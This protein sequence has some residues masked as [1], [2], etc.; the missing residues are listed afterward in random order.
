MRNLNGAIILLIT[1]LICSLLFNIYLLCLEN[2]IVTLDSNMRNGLISITLLRNISKILGFGLGAL[3]QYISVWHYTFILFFT[4]IILR[5]VHMK[6]ADTPLA[7][8]LSLKQ[9]NYR[10][11]IVFL[12]CL[13][14]VAVFSIPQLIQ[15]LHAHGMTTYSSLA[16]MLPG[17][18]SILYLKYLKDT[19]F[20]HHLKLKS[21]TY[22]SFI[23]FY[24]IL[25]YW[26]TFLFIRMIII[27][28]I[29]TISISI[30][31]DIRAQFIQQNSQVALRNL[32][33]FMSLISAL[34]L[35]V[36]SVIALFLPDI[37]TIILIINIVA[38]SILM[39][40]KHKSSEDG[41]ST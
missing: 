4:F 20:N 23:S 14:S 5:T 34:S 27:S 8:I 3:F 30:I 22:I 11:L 36:F 2:Q 9:L 18:F 13:G 7:P 28:I 10:T 25:Q 16:F 29:I 37:T 21:M 32:L 19:R 39:F 1:Y 38:A 15:D 12:L 24:L 40:S 41:L 17:I 26:D 35:L 33:Q 6:N 31:I